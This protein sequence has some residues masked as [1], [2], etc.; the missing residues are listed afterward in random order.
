MAE[1]TDVIVDG[2]DWLSLA[3]LR[4]LST[5]LKTRYQER[6]ALYTDYSAMRFPE[7]S[8]DD[9]AIPPAYKQTAFQI[10]TYLAGKWVENEVGSLT[11]LGL[12]AMSMPRVP[13]MTPEELLDLEAIE[14]FLPALWRRMAADSHKDIYRRFVENTVMHGMGVLKCIYKPK[15]W[16]GMPQVEEMFNELTTVEEM[17]DD[18]KALYVKRMREWSR[19]KPLPFALRTVD[20]ATVYPVWGEYG[21]DAVVEISERPT[22]EVMRLAGAFGGQPISWDDEGR[23]S[24]YVELIEYWDGE[25]MAL[26]AGMGG[27]WRFI[28]G[29]KHGYGRLPYYI[30]FGQETTSTDPRYE[31]VSTLYKLRH[32]VPAIDRALTMFWNRMH[33]TSFP[34]WQV[35]G[36]ID[37]IDDSTGKPIPIKFEPGKIYQLDPGISNN[38]R[39]EPLALAEFSGDIENLLSALISLSAETQ[40]STGASSLSGE[41]GFLRM[42]LTD[43]SRTGYHQIPD[44]V[45]REMAECMSWVLEMIETVVKAPIWAI[46]NSAKTGIQSWIPVF[47]WQI[48]GHYDVNVKVEAFNPLMDIQR[49]NYWKNQAASGFVSER[50]AREQSGIPN[51]GEMEDEIAA[52]RM[53]KAADALVFQRA[54]AGLGATQRPQLE[55]QQ[56]APGEFG[57]QGG[58]DPGA[59]QSPGQGAPVGAP[60]NNPNAVP[61]NNPSSN[62]AAL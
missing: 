49:G 59:P 18:Q 54:L 56:P 12:P 27:S 15:S 5:E 8:P 44:H 30:A 45:G 3:F 47:P 43:L 48:N 28:G 34:A 57:V 40:I 36:V 38:G 53:M 26:A 25:W 10:K 52:E 14:R 41:S 58:R 33:L 4:D 39:I 17:T 21:L 31:A 22:S 1:E 7:V 6:N 60:A 42:Q 50:F 19:K 35:N 9:P 46:D 16:H 55:E 32:T 29:K 20:P 23:R 11:A 51:A 24:G 2:A 37:E 62:G 13:D 61:S